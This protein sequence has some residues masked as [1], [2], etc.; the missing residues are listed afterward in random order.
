MSEGEAKR[1]LR[2][3]TKLAEFQLKEKPI[4]ICYTTPL[5]FVLREGE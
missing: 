1:I 3:K 4:G 5:N 2:A